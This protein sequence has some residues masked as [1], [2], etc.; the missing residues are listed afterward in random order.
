M[1]NPR[2]ISYSEIIAKGEALVG[3][4]LD[5]IG[6]SKWASNQLAKN[7]GN[8]G[9]FIEQRVYNLKQN[10]SADPDFA[11]AGIELKVTPMNKLKKAKNGFNYSAGQR[12]SLHSIDY[13]K[14]ANKPDIVQSSLWHK[15]HK[16]FVIF[17]EASDIKP[18]GKLKVLYTKYLEL[19]RLKDIASSQMAIIKDDYSILQKTIAK[20]ECHCLHEW[21][22]S[23]LAPAPT[24]DGAKANTRQP[25][26]K[27][28]AQKRRWAF[29]GGFMT[30]KEAE[31]FG[32]QKPKIVIKNDKAAKQIG[33]VA[34]INNLVNPYL[35][36]GI[37]EICKK[38]KVP[39]EGFNASKAVREFQ[40]KAK[41]KVS[42]SVCTI[43]MRKMLGLGPNDISDLDA[44]DIVLRSQ[45]VNAKGKPQEPFPL[46]AAI[47]YS[48]VIYVPFE[49]SRLYENLS[50]TYLIAQWEVAKKGK[51]KSREIV[52]LYFRGFK[53]LR[54]TNQDIQG[55]CR[56][57]YV[58]TVSRIKKGEIVEK[59]TSKKDWSNLPKKAFNDVLFVKTH[60]KN[61]SVEIPLPVPDKLTRKTCFRLMDFWLTSDFVAQR[62]Q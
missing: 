23:Y 57:T 33:L 6:Y 8:I 43:V 46:N 18:V 59:T 51:G 40:K 36:K 58:A 26:S 37:I 34:Y 4:T 42:K 50:K 13:F 17:Y 44:S 16:M 62:A 24:G 28:K 25:N 19:N 12:L 9:N 3:K 60:A 49:Y 14:D 53:E 15:C 27:A 7:K 10:N 20:G 56:E 45:R 1:C 52:N 30:L 5:Q 48:S 11:T 35:N 2:D 61:G 47:D 32:K 22:F 54:L 29:K 31:W 38:L 21:M 39:L 41:S 55:K